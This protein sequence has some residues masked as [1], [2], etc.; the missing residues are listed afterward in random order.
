MFKYF[1][2]PQKLNF[3]RTVVNKLDAIGH[4]YRTFQLDLLAGEENY[5]T[6]VH[7]AKLRYQLDFSQVTYS[8]L[9]FLFDEKLEFLHYHWF[10]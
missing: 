4:K 3:Y 10:F 2:P 6:E 9:I 1:P 5:K 8:T 7:E